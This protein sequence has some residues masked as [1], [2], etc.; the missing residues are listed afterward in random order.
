MR[1]ITP[2]YTAEISAEV[3]ADKLASAV[4]S[5]SLDVFATPMMAALMEQAACAA[6]APFLE[7]GETTV[8]TELSIRHTAA[9]PQGM[10]VTAKAELGAANGRELVLNVSASDSVGESGSGTHKRFVVY[11]ERFQKKTEKRGK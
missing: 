2:G 1:E 9:T 8:G 11:A 7:E 5:G 10:T 3:T 6:V 4:G